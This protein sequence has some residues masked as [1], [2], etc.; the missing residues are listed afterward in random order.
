MNSQLPH[1]VLIRKV[2]TQYS[3]FAIVRDEQRSQITCSFNPNVKQT[4]T[5]RVP[6]TDDMRNEYREFV[7]QLPWQKCQWVMHGQHLGNWVFVVVCVQIMV[8][9]AGTPCCLISSSQ[10]LVE[11]EGSVFL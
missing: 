2:T 8:F 11:G 10:D 6:A 4:V 5:N 9:W 1:H 3:H 7:L